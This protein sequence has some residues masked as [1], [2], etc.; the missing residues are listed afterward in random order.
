MQW[1]MTTGTW[2]TDVEVLVSE[3]EMIQFLENNELI[4]KKKGREGVCANTG[5][6]K[7]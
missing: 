5:D 3:T 1:A 6:K 4:N 2:D 7:K